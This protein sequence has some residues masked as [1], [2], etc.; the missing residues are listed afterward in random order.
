MSDDAIALLCMSPLFVAMLGMIGG[1]LQFWVDDARHS[2]W[3]RGLRWFPGFYLGACERLH[4][5][6]V[7][8]FWPER[9]VKPHRLIELEVANDMWTTWSGT[10]VPVWKPTPDGR[11]GSW[12]PRHARTEEAEAALPDMT[13][14]EE[15][16]TPSCPCGSGHADGG[17]PAPNFEPTAVER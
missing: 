1:M 17:C 6:V 5:R 16:L 11:W 2:L 10:G 13:L 3:P 4:R 15:W 14:P 12:Q 9:T 8:I 7:K